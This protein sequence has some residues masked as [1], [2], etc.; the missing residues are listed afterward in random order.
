MEA[1]DIIQRRQKRKITSGTREWAEYNVNCI[2][3]C[4]NNCRYCYAKIM[5]KR[6]GHATEKTWEIMRI[7]SEVVAKNFSKLSGRV[8]F[9]SSH[10]IIDIPDV[11][12]ACFTVLYKLLE[13][14]NDVLVTTKP[15]FNV[16]RKI[17]EKF[18]QYKEKLQ[19]RFTITSVDNSLLRFWEPNAPTFEERMDALKYAFDKKYATSVSI[20]PFLDYD[21]ENLVQKVAPYS[22]ESIWIGKMNYISRR[23]LSKGE[24]RYYDKVRKNYEFEHL[25]EIFTKLGSIPKI[26]FKDSIRNILFYK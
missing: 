26:K 25:K 24:K 22:T 19:F 20:E 1:I 18:A 17:D 23:N 4:F 5:A 2:H 15:R 11:E 12:E 9:P 13:S 16:I 14:G 10:D 7:R 3:G 21:P 8:M 6:F